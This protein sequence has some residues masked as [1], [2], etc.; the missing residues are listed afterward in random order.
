[1]EILIVPIQEPP[2]VALRHRAW[3]LAHRHTPYEYN[4][5]GTGSDA[6]RAAK[7]RG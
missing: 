6:C 1:M 3:S 2:V 5:A 4:V 7:V